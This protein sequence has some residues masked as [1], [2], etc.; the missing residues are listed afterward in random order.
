MEPNVLEENKKRPWVLQKNHNKPSWFC[1]SSKSAMQVLLVI[2]FLVAFSMIGMM[3]G[4]TRWELGRRELSNRVRVKSIVGL[5]TLFSCC[6]N[7]FDDP[8]HG[9]DHCKSGRL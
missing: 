4:I 7:T 5:T 9:P 8:Y 3:N 2:R 1:F 6:F